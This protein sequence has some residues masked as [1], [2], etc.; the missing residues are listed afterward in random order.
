MERP[1]FEQASTRK[2]PPPSH[3]LRIQQL[4]RDIDAR[5]ETIRLLNE[6]LSQALI[7]LE[8]AEQRRAA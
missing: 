5:D 6:A 2:A 3:E 7:E 4:R 8:Q 1:N